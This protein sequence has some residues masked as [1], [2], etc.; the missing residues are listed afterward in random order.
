MNQSNSVH[1]TIIDNITGNENISKFWGKHFYTILNF[2]LSIVNTLDD[3]QYIEGMNVICTDV[4]LLIGQLEC[5]K[6]AGPDGVIKFS[7]SKIRILLSLLVFNLCLSHGY[8]P[9]VMIETTIVPIVK[10][11]YGNITDSNNYRPIALETTVSIL[12]ESVL[13][14][15]EM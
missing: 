4:S 1:A 9:P 8:L 3:I 7:H 12:L 10:N 6:S 15:N 14:L 2:E 11:K 5:G 13:S